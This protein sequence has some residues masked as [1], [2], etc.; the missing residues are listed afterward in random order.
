LHIDEFM[1]NPLRENIP[2]KIQGLV[3]YPQT[4]PN[5]EI[6]LGSG[7]CPS[8]GSTPTPISRDKIEDIDIH[9]R[10]PVPFCYR[11]FYFVTI[12]L[13]EF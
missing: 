7:G 6:F 3:T 5:F 4:G 10:V 12:T 11:E 1:N 8:S 9:F 2:K 13:K